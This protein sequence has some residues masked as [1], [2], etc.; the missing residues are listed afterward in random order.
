M[1]TV[2]AIAIST[3]YNRRSFHTM[4]R[5]RLVFCVCAILI[6]ISFISSA[7]ATAKYSREDCIVEIGIN[8]H[9]QQDG[10]WVR[11]QEQMLKIFISTKND[12]DINLAAGLVFSR[13]L[14]AGNGYAYVQYM[15]KCEERVQLTHHLFDKYFSKNIPEFPKYVIYTKHVR[16]GPKTIDM[17]GPYWRDSSE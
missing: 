2:I 12:S 11:L 13:T 15:N 4:N 16:P 9:H 6:V 3:V 7:Y 17:S 10:A 5:K 14:I 1:M 8:M